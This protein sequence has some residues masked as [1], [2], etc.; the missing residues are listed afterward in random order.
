MNRMLPKF[1]STGVLAGVLTSIC[2]LLTMPLHAAERDVLR[3]CA[4]PNSM[5]LSNK[6]QEGFENRIARLLADDLGIPLEY[7]WFPQRR[8]FVRNTLRAEDPNTGREK[9]DLIIGVPTSFELAITT[10]PYYRSTYALVFRKGEG[11]DGV[12]SGRDF[13]TL[14]RGIRDKL[15][16]GIFEQTPGALWISRN[17]MFKQAVPFITLNADPDQYPGQVIEKE[18]IS[19]NIDVAILWG[20]IAGYFVNKSTDVPLAMAPLKSAGGIQF[21]FPISMAVRFG[22]GAWKKELEALLDKNADKI[23]QILSEYKV[24]LVSEDGEPL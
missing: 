20:P 18:L 10:K 7:T 23:K 21:H 9:C 2:S 3:V 8:G 14:D 6:N 15:R 5:P 12:K 4:D 16:I 24:P 13:L 11:L 19:G 1:V 22:E 17:A